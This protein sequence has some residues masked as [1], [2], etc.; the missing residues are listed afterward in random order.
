[1][2]YIPRSS[3][4]SPSTPGAIPKLVKQKHTFRVFGFLATVLIIGAL[5]S[6]VATYL[7]TVVSEQRL[8]SAKEE[9]RNISSNDTQ[10]D[11]AEL[12]AF[13]HRLNTAQQLIANHIAPSK[14]FTGL[15][16]ATKGTVQFISFTYSYDPG[17]QA[18]L[19]LTGGTDQLTS[20]ALQKGEFAGGS[21]FTEFVV[22]QINTDVS[23]EDEAGAEVA[24]LDHSVVFSL[25]GE[26]EKKTLMYTGIEMPATEEVTEVVADQSEE[27]TPA[28]SDA[29]VATEEEVVESND[30]ITE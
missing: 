22:S 4:T 19:E 17:F 8:E 18:L 9:L 6:V 15:E 12:E 2:S 30:S 14:L 24:T 21:V 28:E 5:L 16:E 26:L 29:S 11:I 10:S 27:V 23:S 7:Y 20:V 25:K 13:D 3:I 1:M